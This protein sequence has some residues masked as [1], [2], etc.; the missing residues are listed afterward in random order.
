MRV[1]LGTVELRGFRAVFVLPRAVHTHEATLCCNL[2][3]LCF[4]LFCAASL[5]LR[6]HGYKEANLAFVRCSPPARNP[7]FW[8]GKENPFG[9]CGF[10]QVPSRKVRQW[11]AWTGWC[12]GKR[13]TFMTTSTHCPDSQ[14]Q[15]NS[16]K[17]QPTFMAH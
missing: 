16:S 14:L 8:S 11:E 3:I 6:A 15:N 5:S 7:L 12:S 2:C 17:K 10:I 4:V 13:P 9:H 1:L